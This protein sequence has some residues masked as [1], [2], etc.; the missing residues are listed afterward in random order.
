MPT[1][2]QLLT[3]QLVP[4]ETSFEAYAKRPHQNRSHMNQ[5]VQRLDPGSQHPKDVDA[6]S[7]TEWVVITQPGEPAQL[8]LL[9]GVC[10]AAN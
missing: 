6:I 2:L 9:I 1:S 4:S 5:G 10:C 8:Q 7:V 3:A